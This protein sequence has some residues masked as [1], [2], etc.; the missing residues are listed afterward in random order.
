MLNKICPHCSA[1]IKLKECLPLL[2]DTVA[3]CKYCNKKFQIKRQTILIH[4]GILGATIGIM[5]K[6]ILNS[7]VLDCVIYSV[8]F[9]VIFQRFIDFFYDL[10]A[11]KD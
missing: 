7:S 1:K 8:T 2:Y 3:Y 11:A 10:E 9:V 6:A 4:G 5:A